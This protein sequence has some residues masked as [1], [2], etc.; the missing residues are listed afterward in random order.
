MDGRTD[1]RMDGWMDGQADGQQME[2]SIDGWMDGWMDRWIETVSLMRMR[3][4]FKFCRVHLDV[5]WLKCDAVFSQLS[6]ATAVGVD[7]DQF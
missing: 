3:L 4:D 2:I 5:F 1:G 7:F 6:I